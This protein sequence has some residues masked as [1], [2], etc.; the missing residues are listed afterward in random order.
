MSF[1]AISNNS[2]AFFASLISSLDVSKALDPEANTACKQEILFE[3]L[4]NDFLQIKLTIAMKLARVSR[5]AMLPKQQYSPNGGDT[6][7]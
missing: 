5:A 4:C 3:Q 6:E 1:V 2:V 7:V